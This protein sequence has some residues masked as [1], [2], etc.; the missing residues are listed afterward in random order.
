MG[1][2]NGGR[3]SLLTNG[4]TLAPKYAVATRFD[5]SCCPTSIPKQA[6][7]SEATNGTAGVILRQPNWESDSERG[8]TPFIHDYSLGLTPAHPAV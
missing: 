6:I 1:R 2:L 7:P 8:L 3:N 5:W 4:S